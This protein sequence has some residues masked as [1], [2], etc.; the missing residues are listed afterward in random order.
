MASEILSSPDG[1]FIY[2]ANRTH[3]S[4]SCFSVGTKG[5]L[6][7]VADEPSH[8][9]FPRTFNFDPT[10]TFVYA[11][12]QRGDNIAIFRVDR[13]SGRLA[14]TGQYAAVGTPA[15]IVFLEVGK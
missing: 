6:T 1:R 2:A 5:E 13:D 9:N 3:D 7:F 12:N 15:I 11:C 10:G 4:I 8:G 14:F